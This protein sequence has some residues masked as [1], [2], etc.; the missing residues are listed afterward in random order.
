M[1]THIII[2]IVPVNFK[3]KDGKEVNGF[4]L[5]AGFPTEKGVGMDVERIWVKPAVI[6]ALTAKGYSLSDL[7][8]KKMKPTYNRYGKV[9]TFDIEGVE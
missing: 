6:N 9:D 7:I 1:Y 5:L 4:R 8:N 2:G 3:D